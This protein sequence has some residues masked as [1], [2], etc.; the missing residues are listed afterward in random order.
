MTDKKKEFYVKK[1]KK[2]TDIKDKEIGNIAVEIILLA[3][4]ATSAITF[5]RALGSDADVSFMRNIFNFAFGVVSLSC[6][7]MLVKS[8]AAK[9][10]AHAKIEEIK[11]FFE[12]HGLV[13]EDEISKSKGK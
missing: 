6:V 7:I 8:I 10:G 3:L 2:Y 12:Q 1:V 4:M 11:E 13:L 9:I 5:N